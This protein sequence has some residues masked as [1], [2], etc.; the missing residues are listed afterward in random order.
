M[1]STRN[2]FLAS[3][4]VSFAA[5]IAA[6]GV[7]ACG[8]SKKAPPDAPNDIGFNKPKAAMQAN[9]ETGS[10][11]NVWT[12]LGSADF[13]CLNT[14]GSNMPTTETITLNTVVLDFQDQ[15]PVA[16]VNVIAFPNQ[17]YTQPFGS[18]MS[19]G[20]GNVSF[21]I[22][23]GT[24]IFGFEMTTTDGMTFP[25]FLMNQYINPTGTPQTLSAGKIQDVSTSTGDTLPA[26]IGVTRT[27]GTGVL[28]GA[29]RDCNNNEVSNFVATVSTT[30]MTVSEVSGES[31]YYFADSVG[32][33]VHHCEAG[34]CATS[35]LDASSAD[36]LFMIIQ[37]PVA[38]SAYV[39]V[40]GY[41]TDAALASD[42]LQIVAQLQVPVL[43]DTVIT[44][45][46]VPLRTQ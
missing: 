40:W 34:T 8:G 18:A 28:A 37:L 21:T 31:T 19:D 24:E 13:S 20:S 3:S 35:Q 12:N 7:V 2:K 30:S 41:P 39:Q 23:S 32:L 6:M 14:A 10:N 27:P 29:F 46:Y 42:S 9:M 43:A 1:Q 38:Q 15:T 45:S 11:T 36:G 44:G 5:S 22:P 17:D 25:T 4:I 33:P 26:L 16:N